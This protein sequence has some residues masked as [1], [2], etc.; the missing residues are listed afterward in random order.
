MVNSHSLRVRGINVWSIT[1]AEN[2]LW[3]V[4]GQ[5]VV[6]CNWSLRFLERERRWAEAKLWKALEVV[7]C[8]APG[9]GELA[10]VLGKEGCHPCW[11]LTELTLAVDCG[12]ERRQPWRPAVRVGWENMKAWKKVVA[13]RW[14][15]QGDFQRNHDKRC[16]PWHWSMSRIFAF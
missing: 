7:L 9:T 1:L 13:E 3:G 11:C 15:G 8:P 2:C 12:L 14:K 10:E 4:V 6:Q 5:R 16:P